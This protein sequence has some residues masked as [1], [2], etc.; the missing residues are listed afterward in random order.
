MSN[1]FEQLLDYLVNEEMD[2]ANELF[3]EIVVEKSR[4]IYENMIAEEAEEESIEEADAE[5]DNDLDESDADL[6]EETTLEIGGDQ[7]DD[8][9]V[10]ERSSRV[11]GTRHLDDRAHTCVQLQQRCS[12]DD[13]D[14]CARS[15]FNHESG[16]QLFHARRFG[17]IRYL[18]RQDF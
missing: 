10:G 9:C 18:R 12:H 2:K 14:P 8:C 7:A 16:L 17:W 1:K 15:F 5:N 3:H 6:E 13:N 11:G 4:E